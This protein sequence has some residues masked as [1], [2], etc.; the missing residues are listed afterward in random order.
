MKFSSKL[1]QKYFDYLYNPVYDITTARLNQYRKLQSKCIE[2]LD[3]CEN[4]RVLCVGLGTGNELVNILQKKRNIKITGVDYSKT[5]LRKASK[6]A[7]ELG[8]S[9][10]LLLQDA[11]NLEFE[12]G[13]FDRVL[14]IHVMDFVDEDRQ[15]TAELLR[16]LRNEGTFVITYPSDRENTRMGFK[17]LADSVRNKK[18]SGKPIVS[19]YLESLLQVIAGIAYLPLLFR[20]NR[21]SYQRNELKVLFSRISDS[22]YSIEEDLLYQDYIVYGSKTIKGGIQDAS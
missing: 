13:S 19:I 4:D 2:K 12:A 17:L 15:V 3:L 1:M 20:T 6:K 8:K 11:R 22:N 7:R 18:N 9:V 21:K 5:A 14:C 16:V 10:E